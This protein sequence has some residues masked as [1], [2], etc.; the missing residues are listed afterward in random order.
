MSLAVRC[1][2]L[3]DRWLLLWDSLSEQG[4]DALHIAL[5]ICESLVAMTTS[6]SAPS[7]P[8]GSSAEPPTARTVGMLGV[9]SS[10]IPA[11]VKALLHIAPHADPTRVPTGPKRK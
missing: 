1:C 11:R 7:L 2:K 4:V 10:L 8:P 9:V 5:G 3:V 6:S